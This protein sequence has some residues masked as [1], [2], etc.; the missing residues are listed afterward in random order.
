MIFVIFPMTLRTMALI[1]VGLDV[2]YLLVSLKGQSDGVAHWVHLGGAAFGFLWARQGAIWKDPV[3]ELEKRRIAQARQA[4]QD[5]EARMDQLL[6]RIN[7]DGIS[8]LSDREREFLK[9]MSERHKGR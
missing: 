7:R 5:D 1:V 3:E 9:R 8:S 6:D 2:F 4:A